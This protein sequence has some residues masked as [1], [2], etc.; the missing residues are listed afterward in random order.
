MFWGDTAGG[1]AIGRKS[2][3]K[4]GG[5]HVGRDSQ[6]L[7]WSRSPQPMPGSRPHPAEASQSSLLGDLGLS[8]RLSR[9]D[10]VMDRGYELCTDS[11]HGHICRAALG[12]TKPASKVPKRDLQ[13]HL[14]TAVCP[15]C[16]WWDRLGHSLLAQDWSAGLG[17]LLQVRTS[18]RSTPELC[19]AVLDVVP[20]SC[21]P[22]QV[23]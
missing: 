20:L 7:V 9:S 21:S 12:A 22:L 13:I 17:A 6:G 23:L 11:A 2:Q 8:P 18:G 16:R 10:P 15:V 4:D 14:R 1:L 5:Q 3:W 19:H